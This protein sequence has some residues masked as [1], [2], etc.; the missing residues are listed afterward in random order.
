MQEE[1]LKEIRFKTSRSQGPGGQHVNKVESRVDLVF[2]VFKSDAL[3]SD[4][5]EI[6][7][8]KLKNRI[9]NDGLLR[10]QCDVTKSQFKNKEIVTEHFLKLIETA[11]K[12]EKK[13]KP[14]KP[15]KAA[16]EKRLQDKKKQSDKK[17]F[18]KPPPGDQN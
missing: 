4:Q 8:K 13:R 2:D 14:T 11:L 18:R 17:E 6:V 5:I 15:G 9:S 12:P 1:L 7:S 3:D 10:L 16:K